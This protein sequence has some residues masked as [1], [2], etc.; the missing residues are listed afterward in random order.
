MKNPFLVPAFFIFLFFIMLY[1][2]PA[3][4]SDYFQ[5][6][7]NYR[8]KAKLDDRKH[9][10][11]CSESIEY[12]NNSEDTLTFIYFHLWPNAYSGNHTALA[13][14]LS[15]IGGEKKN[16]RDPSARGYIDSIRFMVNNVPASM[17]L[18]DGQPDI[19][20]LILPKILYPHDSLLITT[21]FRVKIPEGNISRIGFSEGIYQISQWYPKPAVYDRNGWHPMSYLDQGEFYSEFGTY[22]VEISVPENY[23]VAASGKLLTDTANQTRGEWIIPGDNDKMGLKTLSYHGEMIHDFAWFA[24]KDFIVRTENLTLP[25]SG[26]EI[27]TT[28]IFTTHQAYLWLDA[29]S[30]IRN[31][32]LMFSEWIGDYPYDSF[33]AVQAPIAAGSGMEYPGVAVIGDADEA[34]SLENVIAHEVC[35]SWFYGAIASDERNYPYM[36]EGLA[37]AYEVRYMNHFYP[38]KKLWEI[39]LQNKKMARLLMIDKLPVSLASELEWLGAVRSNNEQPINLPAPAYT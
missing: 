29:L 11:K 16:F 36:D 5:Q 15:L 24:G 4:A 35:H 12:Y 3:F 6:R 18:L 17:E 1:S 23:V 39:F 30:Y 22:D 38:D 25:V 19:C 14:Q 8:I 32:I 10:L 27:S 37:T 33:T 26:K 28:I 34:Y 31:S 7:V 9:E 21:P 20:K 13:Q 2:L